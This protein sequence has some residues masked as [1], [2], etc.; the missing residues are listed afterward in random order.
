MKK[1]LLTSVIALICFV[2]NAQD[3]AKMPSPPATVVGK[4]NNANVTIKYHQPSIKGRN[5]WEALAP[6][7]KVWR[8]GANNATTIEIDQDIKIEG[9]ALAKGKYALFTIPG[10]KEWVIIINSKAAQWGAYSYKADEDVLRVT[11]P[12]KK[13]TEF[14]EVFLISL[15]KNILTLNWE[16]V[17]VGVKLN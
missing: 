7:G 13:S 15:D 9:K 10:E 17:K 4:V 8:T 6:Y 16:N 3:K 12:V 11:V 2:S 14:N 1:L 5:V